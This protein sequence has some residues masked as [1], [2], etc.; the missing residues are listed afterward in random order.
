MQPFAKFI[1]RSSFRKIESEISL[2]AFAIKIAIFL[3]GVRNILPF[4]QWVSLVI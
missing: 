3:L 4:W 1:Q 2:R